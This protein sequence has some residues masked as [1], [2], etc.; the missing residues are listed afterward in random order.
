MQNNGREFFESGVILLYAHT[1]NYRI[2]GKFRGCKILCK[3][4]DSF[5]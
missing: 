3:D 5:I 2:V 1:C 4:T